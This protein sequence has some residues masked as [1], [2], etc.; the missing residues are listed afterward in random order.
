MKDSVQLEARI[1]EGGRAFFSHLGRS[2]SSVFSLKGW[3]SKMM[4]W[5]MEREGFKLELFRFID[6]L[7]NLT[8]EEMVF[9]YI[10]EHF[11]SSEDVPWLMRLGVRVAG[12]MGWFG[13][14]IVNGAVHVGL[15]SVGGQFILGSEPDETVG[16]LRRLRERDGYAF[17]LDVLGEETASETDVDEYVGGYLGLLG[18]LKEA[19]PCWESL[20]DGGD[21]DWGSDPKVNISVK[22]SALCVNAEEMDFEA[23]VAQM[24]SKIKPVY[25]QV[26]ALGGYMCIDI[27]TLRLR[28][29]IFE[30]FRRLRSDEEFRGYR[31]LGLAMQVYFKDHDEKLDEIL[32]WA[33]GELLPISIRLVK[34]AYWD[35]EVALAE[36]NGVAVPVYTIKAESDVAFERAAEK[37]LRNSDI[38]HLACASHNVRS[39]VALMEMA[40]MLEVGE[41][42]LEFQVLYGMAEP[43]RKALSKMTRRVRL[44]CPHGDLVR[45]MAYLVRRMIENSSND[46]VLNLVFAEGAERDCILED[47]CVTLEREIAMAK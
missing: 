39:V 18:S 36:E 45:G 14:K 9:D 6:E 30:L 40:R 29:I 22:P 3:V 23:A 25:R 4:D 26:V 1:L 33:R 13:R 2:R 27:E 28:E 44:Y 31:H 21:L 46:S 7:P 12:G 38:C 16:R 43:F 47:P 19:L 41:D 15:K 20:G 42:R 8:S 37:I 11:L 5:S 35:Y 34:G 24:L 32:A 10:R 17:T